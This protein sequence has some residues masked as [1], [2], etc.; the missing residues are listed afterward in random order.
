MTKLMK[1]YLLPAL[2]VLS[3]AAIAVN[4]YYRLIK[5]ST[6]GKATTVEKLL[7]QSE[8]TR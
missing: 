3:I 5:K 4:V 6:G 8:K 7:P 1:Q 2:I